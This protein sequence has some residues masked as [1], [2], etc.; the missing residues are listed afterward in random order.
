M[1]GEDLSKARLDHRVIVEWVKEGSSVLEPG[2]GNGDLLA[3]LA[4]YKGASVSGIE[5]DERAIFACVS[6]GLSV[7]HQ[8]IDDGLSEYADKAF[9]YVIFNQCLQEVRKPHTALSA[10]VRVG[11]KAVIGFA[12]FAQF[13]ARI[14]LGLQGIAPV[15]PAL[16]YQW[17]DTPNLHFLS[18]KDFIGYCAKNGLKIEREVFLGKSKRISVFPNLRAHLGVFEISAME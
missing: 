10:A 6:R 4:K 15:T 18:I 9:D 17:Y 12:N 5:I 2:C 7:A 8:D 16:P 3:L 14:Q 1:N 11:R 13:E